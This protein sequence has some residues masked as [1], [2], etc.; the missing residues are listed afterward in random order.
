MTQTMKDK[1][2]DVQRKGRPGQR[3][4]E[5]LIRIARRRRRRQILL[6][7]SITLI[8]IAL[9]ALTFWEYH[10]ITTQQQ[11]ATQKLN[12]QHATATVKV[13]SQQATATEKVAAPTQTAAAKIAEPTQ[14]AVANASATVVA[15]ATITVASSEVRT[16]TGAPMPT[17]GPAS[18]PAVSGKTVTL[19]GNLKYIDVK[20]G[21]GAVVQ[22]TST[23]E[24]EYSGWIAKSGTLFDSSY[25]HGGVPFSVPLGQ[26]KVIPGWDQGLV[27]MK[28]G[29]TRRLLIPSAL[30]YGSSGYPPVIPA[31][32]D[33][34]FDVT[35]L[36]VS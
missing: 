27:G 17:K 8:V 36:S 19:T 33:L 30:G 35:L 14:T 4:Q 10:Q 25:N 21:T 18:P 22:A 23:V 3:Q 7:S 34:V 2:N 31:N 24:V 26:Q 12:D 15:Q 1:N 11:A 5:R 16:I 9:G 28:V 6:G 29:G 20:E 13:R 32:A